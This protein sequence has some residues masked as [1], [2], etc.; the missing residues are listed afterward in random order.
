MHPT[1][2]ESILTLEFLYEIEKSECR[3]FNYTQ[4]KRLRQQCPQFPL[5]AIPYPSFFPPPD[6]VNK[7]RNFPPPRRLA[8]ATFRS[9]LHSILRSISATSITCRQSCLL[10]TSKT[11]SGGFAKGKR[12]ARAG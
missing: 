11:E 2:F 6:K 8:L 7:R 1:H 12:A 3:Q 5:E 10:C 9:P 4:L